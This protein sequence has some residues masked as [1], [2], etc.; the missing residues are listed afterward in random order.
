M[1]QRLSLK[2]LKDNGV[3]D[4][5][6][7][8]TRTTFESDF[9]YSPYIDWDY[10]RTILLEYVELNPEITKG[11]VDWFDN[12]KNSEQYVYFNGEQITM[13]ENY[14]V[15]NPYTGTYTKYD[16]EEEMQEAVIELSKQILQTYGPKVNREIVNENGN[17]AWTSFDVANNINLIYT[18]G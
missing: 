17:V 11:W 18:Q 8:W 2:F 7:E 1:I 10:G 9:Q 3:C 15:Y 12:L 13:T 16:S 6:Y 14:Q 5:A 4:E